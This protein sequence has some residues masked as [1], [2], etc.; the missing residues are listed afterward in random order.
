MK[1][2]YS[3]IA[4]LSAFLI[5]NLQIFLLD[6]TTMPPR[7]IAFGI[8][9]QLE[10]TLHSNN[11]SFAGNTQRGMVGYYTADPVGTTGTPPMDKFILNTMKSG[12][13]PFWNPYTL[14]GLPL[15]SEYFW[16][17]FYPPNL[18]KI[19]IPEAW[20][21]MYSALHI[22]MLSFFIYLLAQKI[23][24]GKLNAFFAA[25]G[26][27]GVGFNLF[28]FPIDML[29]A[30]SPW[31]ILLFLGAECLTR[32]KWSIGGIVSI[33][34]GVYGI[35][36]AGHPTMTLFF[37][38]SYLIYLL[39]RLVLDKDS[40][41]IL[42]PISLCGGLAIL[43]ATPNIAPFI[44][45]TLTAGASAL[46]ATPQFFH[47]SDFYEFIF[48]YVFGPLHRPM[49]SLKFISAPSGF[50]LTAPFMYFP[51]FVGAWYGIRNR[52][53]PLI[54]MMTSAFLMMAWGFGI[55]P[56]SYLSMLPMLGRLNFH[57][58]WSMPALVLCLI[59][60][61]CLHAI[62]YSNV[63]D[64]KKITKYY[65]I[66]YALILLSLLVFIHKFGSIDQ[67]L[68]SYLVLSRGLIPDIAFG[69]GGAAI[70]LFCIEYLEIN[71]NKH[72]RVGFISMVMF[73]GF[74]LNVA[75]IYPNANPV[76]DEFLSL[77]AFL[78]FIFIS[79]IS[80]FI[81][82]KKNKL[83]YKKIL[84][85][86]YSFLVIAIFILLANYFMPG[87]SRRYDNSQP[88]MFLS[89]LPDD[90][91]N[92]RVYGMGGV[93][94]TN[95]L[96]RFGISAVNN[97]G[98]LVPGNLEYFFEGYL[99]QYQGP[100]Q[101]YGIQIVQPSSPG[102]EYLR[103]ISF[104][105]YI[106]VKYLIF[107]Q[108]AF[109]NKSTLWNKLGENLFFESQPLGNTNLVV[110]PRTN[111]LEL[112][113]SDLVREVDC[114]EGAFS[115][116]RLKI[117][118]YAKINLGSLVVNVSDSN[119]KKLI[120]TVVKD[121]SE[122]NDAEFNV[123]KLPSEICSDS[124]SRVTI[125]IRHVTQDPNS[126]LAVWRSGENGV[127]ILRIFSKR[128][129]ANKNFQIK[130]Y[131]SDDDIGVVENI[132]AQPRAYFSKY[133]TNESDWRAALV[134]FAGQSDLRDTVFGENQQ[135]ACISA[136]IGGDNVGVMKAAEVNISKL[137]PNEVIID[138]KTS[139][140][141]TL[142]L[143]DTFMPGWIASV[144]GQERPVFRVNGLFRGVCIDSAGDHKVSMY[145][146]PVYWHSYVF[147][148][149]IGFAGF[150]C[151]LA[152]ALVI[153]GNQIFNFNKR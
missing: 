22:I 53:I 55:P 10:A 68:D 149:L 139:S 84:S 97:L 101:F 131:D 136:S 142:V 90:M 32:E 133:F 141:G 3:F 65:I 35:G 77:A 44:L 5:L 87:L 61:Y 54:A 144:D 146:R 153:T 6:E 70:V 108:N 104:W 39:V 121:S 100:S 148:S 74:G 124:H 109:G 33:F 80:C 26:V 16:G 14:T 106:G 143:V 127:D 7:S 25:V 117:G 27:F 69:V 107:N 82:I 52:N 71:T 92:W 147:L 115:A 134:S 1:T 119:S 2:I 78:F 76:A 28:Y 126:M 51:A 118:T 105:N 23:Y 58:I 50:M 128:K 47:L 88:P 63:D 72:I 13:I 152:F 36:T 129:L 29:M 137:S 43:A 67:F 120:A 140:A 57:Y 20:G 30:V 12:Q 151:M 96:A 4:I 138:A 75:G 95:N 114:S 11:K 8:S 93:V 91:R 89:F 94:P 110:L 130:G 103:K 125:K 145:Y 38:I 46:N 135:S 60:G 62:K 18:L 112:E 83:R 122:V 48:P 37:G 17:I 132:D 24:R 21:D 31:G 49:T 111:N 42:L 86:R 113:G 81:A 98:V 15:A 123:F 56:I 73:L 64:L 34:L 85:I 59:A 45:H 102:E 150:F 9:G 99:D 66:L 19:I 116:L 79:S 41:G 40:R